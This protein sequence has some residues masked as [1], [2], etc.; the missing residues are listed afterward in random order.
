M[1]RSASKPWRPDDG[2][3]PRATTAHA[4]PTSGAA[5]RVIAGTVGGRRLLAPKGRATRPTSDRVKEALFSALAPHLPGA[6]VLDLYAGSGALGIEALSRGASCAVF[7]ERDPKAA[8]VIR[9][10]LAALGLRGGVVHVADT[11]RYCLAPAGAPFDVVVADPPYSV[12]LD[13][14]LARI[15]DLAEVGGLAPGAVVVVE[16]RRGDLSPRGPLPPGGRGMAWQRARAYGDTI[17]LWGQGE[18]EQR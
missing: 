9:A 7:V 1:P 12:G 3:D 6:R 17:L 11:A 18:E 4:P 15:G 5:V 2:R 14:V 13:E 10:N 8:A 16:R